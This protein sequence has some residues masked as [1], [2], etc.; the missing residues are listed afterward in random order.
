YRSHNRAW[1]DELVA[2][3]VASP[4]YRV[5]AFRRG[6]VVLD[7]IARERL[8]E[9]KGKRLL[10]LQC[11]FGLDTL[12]I[13]RMGAEVTGVDFSPSA[14]A[15]ARALAKETGLPATFVEADVLAPPDDLTGF[16]FAFASWGA[17]NWIADLDAWMRTAAQALKP[18]G[19]LLVIEGHP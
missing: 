4:F 15:T 12:S 8:T 11:H 14:I 2:H 18:G 3:H 16:D 5:D 1:W 10:H 7:P 9:V 19:R 17:I 6:E 13:A